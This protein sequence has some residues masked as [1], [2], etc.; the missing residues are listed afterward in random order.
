MQEIQAAQAQFTEIQ[1][2]LQST[3]QDMQALL[4]DDETDEEGDEVEQLAV[5][6]V[7][8]PRRAGDLEKINFEFQTESGF[9]FWRGIF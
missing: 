3:M 2:K 1:W 9:T 6:H 5:V 8:E 4:R 7:V